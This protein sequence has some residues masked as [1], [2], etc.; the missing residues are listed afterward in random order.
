MFT[1]ATTI[2]FTMAAICM[3]I[4]VANAGT[5][6]DIPLVWK[7]SDK[8]SEMEYI[9][10]SY[11]KKQPVKVNTFTDIRLKKNEIGR[12]SED[13]KNV[14]LVTTKDD[15]AEWCTNRFKHVIGEFGVN[16]SDA[17][18]AIII[19]GEI[20]RFYVNEES[21]YRAQVVIKATAKTNNGKK[22]WEGIIKDETTRWGRSYSADNYYEALGNAFIGAI[23]KWLK[24]ES[25]IN[26]V[27]GN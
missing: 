3:M 2:V 7:P 12:N 26:A 17:S 5:L 25:F 21:L 4:T 15:V 18:P 16:T 13:E 24:D 8:V 22:I 6:Q 23:Y 14:K 19:D 9:D 1:K 11:I 27:K 10:L 20:E